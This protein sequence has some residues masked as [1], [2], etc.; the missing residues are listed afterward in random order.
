MKLQMFL[1]QICAV[2]RF[3]DKP[4]ERVSCRF[5]SWLY[6]VDKADAE[7]LSV[8]LSVKSDLQKHAISFNKI[9]GYAS[10]GANVMMGGHNSVQTTMK[11]L[12]PEIFTMKC[13]AAIC[14]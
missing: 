14:V 2:V 12:V 1:L 9:V 5:F 8:R 10:D 3:F 4:A 11:D 6:E 7:T 13:S